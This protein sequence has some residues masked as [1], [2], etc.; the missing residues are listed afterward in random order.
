MENEKTYY[1]TDDEGNIYFSKL[2][3][4][5]AKEEA[6]KLKKENPGLRLYVDEETV[7]AIITAE[8]ID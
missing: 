4:Q 1:V 6:L 3:F 5:N 7:D 8:I 2:S